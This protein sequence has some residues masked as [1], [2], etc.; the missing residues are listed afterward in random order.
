MFQVGDFH[1]GFVEVVQLQNTGQQ[2]EA[3]DQNTGEEFRQSKC[4]QTNGCQPE[5]NRGAPL[6]LKFYT[7][8]FLN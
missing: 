5:D 3:R 2:E 7:C 6:L 1:E 8:L 4:L